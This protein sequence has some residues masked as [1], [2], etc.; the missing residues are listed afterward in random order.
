MAQQTSTKPDGQGSRLWT[1]MVKG[2]LTPSD[3]SSHHGTH[4]ET[5]GQDTTATSCQLNFLST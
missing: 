2:E 4:T 3:L 5:H 1:H